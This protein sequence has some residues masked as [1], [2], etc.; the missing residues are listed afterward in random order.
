MDPTLMYIS[1]VENWKMDRLPHSCPFTQSNR[2]KLNLQSK[3]DWTIWRAIGS[4]F[5]EWFDEKI[6]MID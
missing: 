3:D 4:Q 5:F 2:P 6:G 1:S